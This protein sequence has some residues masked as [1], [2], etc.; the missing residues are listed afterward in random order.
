MTITL[1]IQRSLKSPEI[2]DL[3]RYAYSNFVILRE[4]ASHISVD[5]ARLTS[6]SLTNDDHFVLDLGLHLRLPKELDSNFCL[7]VS[8]RVFWAFHD[9]TYHS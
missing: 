7:K 4:L 6:A 1:L 8:K 2:K 9:A 3:L 5:D